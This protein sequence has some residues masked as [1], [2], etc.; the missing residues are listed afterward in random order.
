MENG[1][2]YSNPV[3]RFLKKAEAWAVNSSKL[4]VADSSAI[5]AYLKQEYAVTPHFIPYGADIFTTPHPGVLQSYGLEPYQ[6][7]LAIARFEPENN[8]ETIICGYLQSGHTEPLALIGS[9]Q[10]RYG[11]ELYKQYGDRVMFLGSLYQIE[12]LNNLRFFSSL[13]FHG[14]SVGGTNPSLLEA[15]GLTGDDMRARQYF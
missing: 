14:H 10:N 5:Q 8:I 7:Y 4:L 13:Y 12:Q 9:Y 3:R 11:Q 15:S 2:K 1:S 6:Y